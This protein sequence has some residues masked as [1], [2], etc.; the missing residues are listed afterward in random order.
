MHRS[1]WFAF[2]GGMTA[3]ACGAG[4]AAASAGAGI[5]IDFEAVPNHHRPSNFYNGGASIYGGSGRFT[6]RVGPEFGVGIADA[7]I[8]SQR[9]DKCTDGGCNGVFPGGTSGTRALYNAGRSGSRRAQTTVNIAGGF[10]G[11]ASVFHYGGGSTLQ[12]YRDLGGTTGNGGSA[13]LL[14][15]V[16]M[17]QSRGCRIDRNLTVTGCGFT[18]YTV[19]FDGA[20]QSIV[21][22][23]N[24]SYFD[25]LAIGTNGSL[26]GVPDLASWF[27]LTVGLGVVGVALR[28]PRPPTIVSA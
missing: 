1:I 23:G 8:V 16:S 4:V 24:A 26:G 12:V 17:P 7:A 14:G 9:V 20:A 18:R 21:L 22:A 3:A 5:V 19:H 13:V 25:D 15:S 11:S 2:I 6:S 28:R 10:T 27:L